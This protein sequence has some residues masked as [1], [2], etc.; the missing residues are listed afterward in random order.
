VEDINNC[1][2]ETISVGG[3]CALLGGG[4]SAASQCSTSA[5]FRIRSEWA[6]F[7][8]CPSCFERWKEDGRESKSTIS[9]LEDEVA[10]AERREEEASDALHFAEDKISD[11]EAEISGLQGREEDLISER[12]DLQ[13]QVIDLR[14]ELDKER[15]QWKSPCSPTSPPEQQDTPSASV[16]E[17]DS[18]LSESGSLPEVVSDP[19]DLDPS[20]CSS[21]SDVSESDTTTA[22]GRSNTTP[23]SETMGDSTSE[24]RYDAPEDRTDALRGG[25]VCF[26]TE[27]RP[28]G[29]GAVVPELVCASFCGS[30]GYAFVTSHPEEIRSVLEDLLKRPDVKILGHSLAFDLSVILQAFPD[31]QDLVLAGLDSERFLDT[32]IREMLLNLAEHGQIS[33]IDNPDGTQTRIKYTLAALVKKYLHRD[34]SGTKEQ[35]SWRV[36]YDLLAHIPVSEW[37]PAAVEYAEDDVRLP[38]SVYAE[39]EGRR[40]KVLHAIGCDPLDTQ[41]FRV[42][43][44]FCLYQMGARGLAVDPEA[45][46]GIAEKLE[47]ELAPEK[48]SN[49]IASGILRPAAPSQPYKGGQ[50]DHEEGC[51]QIG[52]KGRKTC[53]CPP[54]MKKAKKESVDSKRLR[55]LVEEVCSQHGIPVRKTPK[56]KTSTDAQFFEDHGH[57]HPVLQEYQHR[58][59]LQKV[60]TTE[61]PRLEWP[62]GSGQ[63]A[64]R[65]HPNFLPLKETGRISSFGGS[66][67]PSLNI[68]NVDPRV[69]GCLVASPGYRLWSWDYSQIELCTLA[70]RVI[71]LCADSKLA[72][73]INAGVDVHAYLGAQIAKRKCEE[74]QKDLRAEVRPGWGAM[75]DYELFLSWKERNTA[76]QERYAYYRK[77]AKP[78]GLGLPGGMGIKGLVKYAHGYGIDISEEGAKELVDIWHQTFPEMSTYF[79]L[80]RNTM[81]D[82]LHFDDRG[83]RFRYLSDLGMY[84]SNMRY[85]ACCNGF[86]LQTTAAE[87]A[88]LALVDLQKR[89]MDQGDLL[90]GGNLRLVAMIHDE[91]LGEIRE[92]VVQEA[93][94][95]Q[96]VEEM[97]RGMAQFVPDVK[98]RVKA[99]SLERWE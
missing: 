24:P 40:E 28:I 37:P 1:A 76:K 44:D 49:L 46:A 59:K 74:F 63:T 75:E 43:V 42:A 83:P 45:K 54:K 20:P 31:L 5:K 39:Q 89:M 93:V 56:G 53:E 70:Q 34:I 92:G 68:Q 38:L 97:V 36:N 47:A 78:V 12:D 98:I 11:L 95:A 58:Q 67:Y 50:I 61:L 41:D 10:A 79:D 35:G 18:K 4:T 2:V 19:G 6:C 60:A 62:K 3:C 22:R 7:F 30:D 65:V 14:T 52:K 17:T 32:K 87:G 77:A 80:V 96:V 94:S 26:D 33:E 13:I 64:E 57:L 99:K 16:E 8:L 27:T 72:R 69:R 9:Y 15:D 85:T 88:L 81:V 25:V 48:L 84:R 51:P 21:A 71:D 91:F 55:A 29:P 86:A 82:P 66:L 23:S 73:L 90:G